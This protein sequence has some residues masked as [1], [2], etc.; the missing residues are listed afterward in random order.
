[1]RYSIENYDEEKMKYK[2]D[3][4][5]IFLTLF[6]EPFNFKRPPTVDLLLQGSTV[7]I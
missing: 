7:D 3:V 1:M 4:V 6:A 5:Q 2:M